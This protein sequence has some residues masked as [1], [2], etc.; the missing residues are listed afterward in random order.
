MQPWVPL[1]ER[2]PRIAPGSGY[3]G[4][5]A[6]VYRGAKVERWLGHGP[7]VTCIFRAASNKP[8]PPPP[9]EPNIEQLGGIPTSN[10]V[11]VLSLLLPMLVS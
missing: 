2:R 9:S 7:L 11:S 1:A 5:A 3:I 8:P 4:L 10:I 6:K